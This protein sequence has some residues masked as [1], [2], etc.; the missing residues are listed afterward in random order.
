MNE[1]IL[2]AISLQVVYGIEYFDNPCFSLLF[3]PFIATVI[4]VSLVVFGSLLLGKLL[5]HYWSSLYKLFRY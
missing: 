3:L 2:Y 4:T 5:L 1:S